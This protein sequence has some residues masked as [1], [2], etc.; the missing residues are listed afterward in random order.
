MSGADP[1]ARDRSHYSYA[2]YANADVAAGFDAL[3]FGGPIGELLAETQ[4]RVI[5]GFLGGLNGLH[6]LDVGTG[7][8]RA[9]IALARRGARVT[10]VD[11]SR[12]MLD[13][14]RARA[15]EAGAAVR[16]EPGDAHA[17]PFT[18]RS[19][20]AAVSLRVLMHT[21]GWA[22][23]LAEL[24]RVSRSR[25]VFDYPSARSLAALQAAGRRLGAAMGR[26]TEPYR[27]FR[28]GRIRA[29]VEAH[30]FRIVGEHR[31]FV[32]PIAVHKAV[33]SRG[34]TETSERVLAAI[35]L[36]AA[37]GSPITIVAERCAS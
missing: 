12:E 8:G 31:Q 11:A 6:V 30:G 25:V 3:R 34:F 10:G 18:D 32:L 22:Q 37:V 35:G 33:G 21:P 26:R 27:V 24:C 17:L 4:E 2:H 36:N 23:A 5:A 29:A 1:G 16:F 28:P 14:A 15:A 7:T 9:A 20:D 19:F 13:V